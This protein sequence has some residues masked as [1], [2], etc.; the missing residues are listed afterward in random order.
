MTSTWLCD[1]SD[2]LW[3]PCFLIIEILLCIYPIFVFILVLRSSILGFCCPLHQEILLTVITIPILGICLGW[4]CLDFNGLKCTIS[5]MNV[6]FVLLWLLIY[7]YIFWVQWRPKAHYTA[8]ILG[9]VTPQRSKFSNFPISCGGLL[10]IVTSIF[11]L[12]PFLARWSAQ[13]FLRQICSIL[14]SQS[15]LIISLISATRF[16]WGLSS[17]ASFDQIDWHLWICFHHDLFMA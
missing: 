11:N 14:H 12:Q 16:Q 7:I 6:Q 17:V 8:T 10:N 1:Y 4:A 15:L 5:L 9:V 2:A 3:T 13:P